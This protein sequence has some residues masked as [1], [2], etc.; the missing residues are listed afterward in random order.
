MP[1]KSAG[2]GSP[3]SSAP[4][5]TASVSEVYR[6]SAPI[7]S[8]GTSDLRN[9]LAGESGGRLLAISVRKALAPGKKVFSIAMSATILVSYALDTSSLLPS[10]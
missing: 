3:F 1:S 7:A 2:G 10:I 5:A 9:T 4:E 6:N 8:N